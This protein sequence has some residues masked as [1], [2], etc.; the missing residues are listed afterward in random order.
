[1]PS[2]STHA[3][4]LGRETK[5]HLVNHICKVRYQ[6]PVHTNTSVP[7]C[8]TLSGGHERLAFAGAPGTARARTRA[9]A[10]TSWEVQSWSFARFGSVEGFRTLGFMIHGTRTHTHTHTHTPTHAHTHHHTDAGS[11][12]SNIFLSFCEFG[13][14]RNACDRTFSLVRL[15]GLTL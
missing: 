1:M 7:C 2:A 13:Y 5:S 12:K 14:S 9:L 4:G 11:A 15:F 8:G 6:L 3:A 10:A